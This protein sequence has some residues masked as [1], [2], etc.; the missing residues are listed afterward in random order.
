MHSKIYKIYQQQQKN[1]L[2]Q[3]TRLIGSI[4]SG[5]SIRV[6]DSDQHEDQLA[7]NKFLK[8]RIEERE[9]YTKSLD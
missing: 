2:E 1:L 4:F 9:K 5:L 6:R 3:Y 7:A 8:K